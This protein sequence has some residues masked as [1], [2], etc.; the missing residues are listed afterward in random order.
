M[1]HLEGSKPG[2]K[3]S[4]VIFQI[5]PCIKV[6][7][8]LTTHTS[9]TLLEKTMAVAGGEKWRSTVTD[10]VAHEAEMETGTQEV[11][12]FLASKHMQKK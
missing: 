5:S 2:F 9:Q 11:Y 12:M 1:Q 3:L 4:L 6:R 10:Q 8:L 7:N